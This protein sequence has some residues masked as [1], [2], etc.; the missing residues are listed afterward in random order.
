MWRPRTARPIREWK[1]PTL[2]WCGF[3]PYLT[4]KLGRREPQLAAP[5]HGPHARPDVLQENSSRQPSESHASCHVGAI[6]ANRLPVV[7]AAQS[8]AGA[9]ACRGRSARPSSP[10]CVG[11]DTALRFNLRW[12]APPSRDGVSGPESR[13]AQLLPAGRA[14]STG[15]GLPPSQPAACRR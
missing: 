10:I 7:T 6:L 15:D 5:A 11:H 4:P 3:A 2:P 1:V 8:E 12:S 13:P 9:T 14:H